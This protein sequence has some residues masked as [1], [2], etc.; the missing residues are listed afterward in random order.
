MGR[1]L[2]KL[3]LQNFAVF[4]ELDFYFSE[5]IT[6]FVGK[7]MTWDSGRGNAAGKSSL[8]NGILWILYGKTMKGAS[9]DQ[10]ITWGEK[11]CQ[12]TLTIGELIITR[13]KPRGKPERL[14]FVAEGLQYGTKGTRATESR[15]LHECQ[16]LLERHLGLDYRTFLNSVLLSSSNDALNILSSAPEDR[17][18][19]LMTF[20]DVE[21]AREAAE[22]AK[23]DLKAMVALIEEKKILFEVGA[24]RIE[25]LEEEVIQ[26]TET[27]AEMYE[28]KERRESWFRKEKLRLKSELE[29]AKML[30]NTT[31]SLSMDALTSEKRK[32]KGQRDEALTTLTSAL[33]IVK[34]AGGV[35]G[36]F[37][38]K[39]RQP[40]T[41]DTR[42]A[43]QE[44][45]ENARETERL[46]RRSVHNLDR[47]L[48]AL[49]EQM[50]EVRTDRAKRV[51]AK[52]DIE[53]LKIEW[54]QLQD[55]MLPAEVRPMESMLK[56]KQDRLNKQYGEVNV[57][58]TDVTKL[59]KRKTVLQD[60]IQ[61][62]H[63]DMRNFLFDEVRSRLSLYA[64]EYLD[65]Y[66][67]GVYQ[68]QFPATTEKG[69]EK[70]DI[71]LY[72]NGEKQD[73]ETTSEGELWRV[74]FSLFRA[75]R[76][77]LM[78][79]S[80]TRVEFL[81]VD[82]SLGVLDKEGKNAF[83][84]TIKKSHIPQ[85]LVTV[86]GE[87]DVRGTDRLVKVIRDNYEATIE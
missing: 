68:V 61:L 37:C 56:E 67:G 45:I 62:L 23:E 74:R 33:D 65:L 66:T 13:T 52:Q 69:E 73:L 77:L 12:G 7:N 63:K 28:R 81:L 72:R 51:R 22:L 42:D 20:I 17:A 44:E 59:E 24:G 64:K 40:I 46:A 29:R 16:A 55:Q 11:I 34:N 82:D 32:V 41:E 86:P 2:K 27:L 8:L 85:T 25:E 31:D 54:R 79:R 48:E 36:S 57:L 30:I 49:E 71:L 60:A 21:P 35:S 3:S 53:R 19:V 50:E 9:K 47:R 80:H 18:R 10:V 87:D 1:L 83:Y 76:E 38:P 84:E 39:C 26:L 43:L 14:S 5:G 75:I 6:T 4:R 58:R 70:F 78:E 15:R